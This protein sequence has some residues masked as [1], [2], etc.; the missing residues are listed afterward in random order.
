MEA[1]SIIKAAQTSPGRG[2][3]VYIYIPTGTL[4]KIKL[5]SSSP[6][7]DTDP[8]IRCYGMKSNPT[9]C[10]WSKFEYFPICGYQD[11]DF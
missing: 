7:P 2:L 3:E 4:Q 11:M 1:R 8:G 9:G 6:N 10:L 5:L